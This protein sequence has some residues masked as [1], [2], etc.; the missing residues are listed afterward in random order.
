M[1]T[2]EWWLWTSTYAFRR[3]LLIHYRYLFSVRVCFLLPVSLEYKYMLMPFP[4][5]RTN[6]MWRH[7][8]ETVLVYTDKQRKKERS[9]STPTEMD[10][11]T[12]KHMRIDSNKMRMS[13]AMLKGKPIFTFDPKRC[14]KLVWVACVPSYLTQTVVKIAKR[15]PNVLMEI[16]QFEWYPTT[17][18][19]PNGKC[20]DGRPKH[21]H[22]IY[23]FRCCNMS[24]HTFLCKW[25]SSECDGTDVEMLCN[26]IFWWRSWWLS[27][28]VV[29]I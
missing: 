13:D 22:S 3:P 27:E 23:S 29:C 8:Y 18:A 1:L 24:V 20:V 4:L 15:F 19:I 16:Q 14:T 7:N 6:K 17:T 5:R 28:R 21:T 26:D 2:R 25:S 12:H 9:E 11:Y 10:T